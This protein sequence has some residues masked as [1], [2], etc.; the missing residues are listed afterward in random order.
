[1]EEARIVKIE[2]PNSPEFVSVARKALQ[3]IA[4]SMG[5]ADREAEDLE[6]AVGEACTN[7]VKYGEPGHQSV[8]IIYRIEK[9]SVEIE[10]RNKGNAFT[11]PPCPKPLEQL[12]V[13]GLGLFLIE[14][15]MDKMS[16]DCESGET[17]LRMVKQFAKSK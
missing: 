6:L 12:P 4:W 16:I 7:A 5:L 2:I 13:G 9:S 15:L 17:R 10:V 14:Q 3:A 11:P 8:Q 1:M